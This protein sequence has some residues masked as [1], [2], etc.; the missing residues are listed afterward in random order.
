MNEY[1]LNKISTTVNCERVQKKITRKEHKQV[2]CPREKSM[3]SPSSKIP[4]PACI[5]T[6]W[7]KKQQT[8]RANRGHIN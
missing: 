8:R 2:Y 1:K 6:T 3:G 4:P 7:R 5:S